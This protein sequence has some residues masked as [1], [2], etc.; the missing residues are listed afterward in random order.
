MTVDRISGTNRTAMPS[1]QR[2][3]DAGA[4][5]DQGPASRGGFARTF[6]RVAWIS[7]NILLFLSILLTV[8]FITWEYSTRRYLEGFS[9]AIV[10]ATAPPDEKIAGILNWMQ[11]G[12]AR[13]SSLP[14]DLVPNR[15]PT[16]TLNYDALLRVCGT[17]TNAFINL[18]DIGGMPT[19][20][21][22]LLDSRELTKHVVA[23]VLVD[24]RWIVVDP[25]FRVILRGTDGQPLTREQL[26]N[27]EIFA[28]ATGGIDKYDP[29]YTYERTA[30]IRV[31]RLGLLAP[32]VRGALDHLAPGWESSP[33][34]SALVE[35]ESLAATF[36]GITL[37]LFLSLLRVSLRWYGE[38]R[39]GV[40]RARVRTQIAKAYATFLELSNKR[41][42]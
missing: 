8:Y 38:K 33:A 7:V 14:N 23:E 22:L 16:D 2:K 12:P 18:A 34:T 36:A 25:T 3:P 5:P 21:L 24:G 27:R 11:H 1:L 4:D 13:R 6:Y 40:R 30:H 32:A 41:N 29:N 31:G 42:L 35:R 9:D 10:P 17:A 20:R 39:L 28:E 19:R 26:T 15:D 37:V